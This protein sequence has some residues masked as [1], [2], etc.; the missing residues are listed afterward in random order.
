MTR[1]EYIMLSLPL[2]FML[3]EYE[4]IIMFRHW[5]S[6]HRDALRHRFPKVEAW[7]SRQG[8]FGYST[9]T[10]AVGTAHE[11]ILVAAVSSGAVWTGAYEWWFAALVGHSVHLLIHL[12][13]WLIYGQY[14][15]AIFTT[16]LSLPYCIWAFTTYLTASRLSPLHIALWSLGGIVFAALSLYSAHRCMAKFCQ[17]QKA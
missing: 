3:H 1:L 11:F 8:V 13:Q 10:F 6:K 7:L 15:P 4:E 16:V 14:I 12:V 2:V 5:L 9:A 17:W